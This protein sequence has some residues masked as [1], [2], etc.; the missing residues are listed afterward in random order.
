MGQATVTNLQ[1]K[2]LESAQKFMELADGATSDKEAAGWSLAS[3]N[4]A[5]VATNCES[6]FKMRN[7]GR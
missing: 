3:K 7:G 4:A 1:E 2:A 5:A 6:I